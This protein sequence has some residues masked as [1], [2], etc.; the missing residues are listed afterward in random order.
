VEKSCLRCHTDAE[1]DALVRGKVADHALPAALDAFLAGHHAADPALRAD[2]L[3]AL[4][5]RLAA[6]TGD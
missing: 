5:A 2:V 3:A 4:A 6:P 1:L